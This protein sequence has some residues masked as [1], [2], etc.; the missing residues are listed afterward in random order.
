[1][2]A[3]LAKLSRQTTNAHAAEGG[4]LTTNGVSVWLVRDNTVLPV[5]L[6][7]ITKKGVTKTNYVLKPGDKLFIQMKAGK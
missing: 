7:S 3:T 2:H 1:M 5:D 4:S 6:P